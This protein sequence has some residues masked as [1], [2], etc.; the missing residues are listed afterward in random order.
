M[1]NFAIHDGSTIVNVIIAD[2]KEIAEQVTGLQAF[3]TTGQPWISWVMV[4]GEWTDPTP[5]P[6]FIEPEPV[7]QLELETPAE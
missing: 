6:E 5:V 2:S 1:A 3:E 4:D 7:E